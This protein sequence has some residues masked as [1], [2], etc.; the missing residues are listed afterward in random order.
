VVW[1]IPGGLS[2]NLKRNR[3]RNCFCAA[4]AANDTGAE[5]G[6]ARFFCVHLKELHFRRVV[7]RRSGRRSFCTAYCD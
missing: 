1:E 3:E 7:F 5:G 4:S 2:A 6:T